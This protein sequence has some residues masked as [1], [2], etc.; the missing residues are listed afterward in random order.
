MQEVQK[1]EVQSLILGLAVFSKGRPLC[2]SSCHLSCVGFLTQLTS[3]SSSASQV[4]LGFLPLSSVKTFLEL[5][6]GLP[7]ISQWPEWCH[8]AT[9]LLQGRLGSYFAF[10]AWIAGAG[11]KEAKR[12][13]SRVC[14]NPALRILP[15]VS[16]GAS[17]LDDLYK[18]FS[19]HH[20]HGD[21]MTAMD[22]KQM[23]VAAAVWAVVS[24]VVADMEEMLPRAQQGTS[25]QARLPFLTR[26]PGSSASG[27]ASLPNNSIR[28][29]CKEHM[30]SYHY[31]VF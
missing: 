7:L 12:S 8:V 28:F 22:P 30:L 3:N 15:L 9:S 29:I 20:S 4:S 2:L 19:F 21:T 17:L 27:S 10:V 14:Q 1:Q 23:N 5:S 16:P 26:N 18:Y 13:G 31:Y 6:Y 25:N 11:Q 24:Y